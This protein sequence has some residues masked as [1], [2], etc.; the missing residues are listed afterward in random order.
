MLETILGLA[1]A[2]SMASGGYTTMNTAAV[3]VALIASSFGTNQT[4]GTFPDAMSCEGQ[5]AAVVQ[6]YH[7]MR[8]PALVSCVPVVQ[9]SSKCGG[10]F[11]N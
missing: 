4:L 10:Y 5:K 11:P 3:T 6:Q 2:G 9:C 8:K 1:T 7:S